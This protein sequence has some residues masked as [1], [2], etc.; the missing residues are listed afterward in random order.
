MSKLAILTLLVLLSGCSMDRSARCTA[1]PGGIS[2]EDAYRILVTAPQFE[3]QAIGITGAASCYFAA[4]EVVLEDRR[5]VALL[6]RLYRRGT[7]AA[8]IYALD[9]LRQKAPARFA[10]LRRDAFFKSSVTVHTVFACIGSDM[11][12]SELTAIVESG[13]FQGL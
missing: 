2:A 10:Q 5:A 8:R 9:G 12:V 1:L 11:K 3:G 7:P 4:Y 6:E 13:G